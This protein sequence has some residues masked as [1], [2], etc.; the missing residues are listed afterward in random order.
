MKSDLSSFLDNE[1]PAQKQAA[2]IAAMI[3]DEELRRAWDGYHLIGDALRRV[4]GLERDLVTRVMVDLE[5]EP[6]V[7]APQG[8][9]AANLARSSLAMAATAA[10]VAA[11]AWIALDHFPLPSDGLNVA[12]VA[13]RPAA[14]IEK[15][16]NRM[17][18]FLVAHQTYSPTN[19]IQGGTS[20]VRT[21]SVALNNIRQ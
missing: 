12:S 7:L 11:V 9:R 20:Y 19:Q 4:P 13:A 15:P 3:H 1:L 18:E 17:Q 2:V 5:R 16:G 14:A 21:V 10:G 6:V 8:R